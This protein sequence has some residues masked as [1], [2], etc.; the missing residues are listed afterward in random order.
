M[1]SLLL[2][3]LIGIA[4]VVLYSRHWNNVQEKNQIQSTKSKN[5]KIDIKRFNFPDSM[6]ELG[7]DEEEEVKEKVVTKDSRILEG[8]DQGMALKF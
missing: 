7:D 3:F 5:K 8:L 2:S 1:T 6:K 4:E